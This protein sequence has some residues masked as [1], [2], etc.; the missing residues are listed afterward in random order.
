MTEPTLR[1]GA[2]M[3]DQMEALARKI[4]LRYNTGTSELSPQEPLEWMRDANSIVAMLPEPVDTDVQ[5]A[6]D[7]AA[8]VCVDDGCNPDYCDF[9]R[10]GAY[11]GQRE[12]LC[13]LAG[14]KRGREL[15][16]A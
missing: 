10:R 15:A 14:I 12:Y 5:L 8:Q 13:A 3:L 11:D 7:V 16:S 6:R 9:M 1:T 4:A 2:E